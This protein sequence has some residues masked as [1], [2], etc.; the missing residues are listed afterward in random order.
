MPRNANVSPRNGNYNLPH[1]YLRRAQSALQV[2]ASVF[3]V[4]K[5]IA[6][7]SLDRLTID[8]RACA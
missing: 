6:N 5:K 1:E 3:H 7:F 2:T 8:G 4:P